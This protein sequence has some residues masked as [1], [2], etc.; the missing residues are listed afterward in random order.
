MTCAFQGAGNTTATHLCLCVRQREEEGVHS[1]VQAAVIHKERPAAA[2]KGHL[3]WREPHLLADLQGTEH[4]SWES[5]GVLPDV[6]NCLLRLQGWVMLGAESAEQQSGRSWSPKDEALPQSTS[7]Q[8][9]QLS[10]DPETRKEGLKKQ[11]R[12]H[13]AGQQCQLHTSCRHR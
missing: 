7:K 10:C 3:V 13:G 1:K 12:F 5:T 8:Q 2:H 6:H 9:K 4:C 11:G